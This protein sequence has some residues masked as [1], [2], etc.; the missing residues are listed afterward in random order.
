M[1]ALLLTAAIA[2]AG[3]VATGSGNRYG[4][5]TSGAGAAGDS[6][7]G[8]L[9]PEQLWSNGRSA[10]GTSRQQS[11]RPQESEPANPN[12]PAADY[13]TQSRTRG[14]QLPA[15]SLPAGRGREIMAPSSGVGPPN[16]STTQVKPSQLI[17]SLLKPPANSQ[18][19]GSPLSLAEAVGGASSRSEQTQCVEAYWDLTEA[20]ANYYLA[21]R[22]AVALQTLQRGITQPS[23]DWERAGQSLV[24]GGQAALRSVETAQVRLQRMLGQTGGDLPLPSDFPHCGAYDTRYDEIFSGRLPS[25]EAQQL[26][27]LLPLAHQEIR[28]LAADV[29]AAQ[30]WRETVSQRR[31]PQT[32]GSGLLKAHELLSLSRRRFVQ[33][34]CRY[35]V[36]IARYA[37]IA[38]PE[39][40]GTGRLVAMLIHTD[41]AGWDDRGIRRTSGEGASDARQGGPADTF[42]AGQWNRPQLGAT[43]TREGEHSILRKPAGQ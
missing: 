35:N 36:N 19:A 39:R 29:A 25:Y 30:Q 8:Q 12:L 15:G 32:D 6:G 20:T 28:N 10:Q 41:D 13:R 22:E 18:L 5:E 37:E 7:Q 4:T 24:L 2:L 23:A 43:P 17:R 11:V 34:L 38:T 31:D 27:E 14:Q 9:S 33:S 1:H 3:Q 40:V 26:D 16:G 21:L 42:S